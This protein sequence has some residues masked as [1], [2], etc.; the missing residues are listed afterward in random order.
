M[1]N[2][3]CD[4]KIIPNIVISNFF[5]VETENGKK[6][7]RFNTNYDNNTM[8]DLI[9]DVE[10]FPSKRHKNPKI[11]K[12]VLDTI[13]GELESDLEPVLYNWLLKNSDKLQ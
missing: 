12:V 5:T 7:V 11:K 10:Y 6:E 13:E 4:F 3:F 8:L 2:S 9:Q 1:K